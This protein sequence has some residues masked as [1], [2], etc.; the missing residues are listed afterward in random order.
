MNTKVVY[1]L[2]SDEQDSYLEQ[3]LISLY[4]LRYYM[5]N[6]HVTLLT[7]DITKKSL[8]DEWRKIIYNYITECITVEIP[9]NLNKKLRSRFIKTQL[10]NS[11]SGN[12]VYIDC[13]T[14][15][16][17]SLDY[18]D[19]LE[20][21]I[22]AVKDAHC[23][24]S[25]HP[26]RNLFF[27]DNHKIGFPIEKEN[28]YFNGGVFFVKDCK[29]SKDFFNTWSQEWFEG[30]QKGVS[31]DMPSLAK[32]NFL[33]NHLIT[34][35]PAFYNCQLVYGAPYFKS[36]KILHYFSSNFV[37]FNKDYPF[38]FQSNQ[39][40]EKIKK[41]KKLDQKLI[42]KIINPFNAFSLNTEILSGREVDFVHSPL[43]TL[44]RRFYYNNTKLYNKI[45]GL[46]YS[47]YYKNK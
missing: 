40:F 20:C 46:Y 44:L 31:V 19:E 35:L 42:E 22:G 14:I 16:L 7:D 8:E 38:Y 24:V 37:K 17:S 28:Y 30:V 34:E 39:V 29:E 4:S 43:V 12:F 27:I 45:C 2:T 47:L 25:F 23:E 32:S 1:V 10:R 11:I 18:F 26:M 21:T 6:V 13:D 3:L 9:E 5:P 15:I 41:K 36:A 33:H